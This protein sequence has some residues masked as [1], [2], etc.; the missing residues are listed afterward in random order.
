MHKLLSIV[1]NVTITGMLYSNNRLTRHYIACNL[2]ACSRKLLSVMNMRYKCNFANLQ[3][4]IK[5]YTHLKII[6]TFVLFTTDSNYFKNN[7]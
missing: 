7:C 1:N 3:T 5:E 6:T 4:K 2:T